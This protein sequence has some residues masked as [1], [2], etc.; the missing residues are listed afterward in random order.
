MAK[1]FFFAFGS[2]LPSDYSGLSPTFIQYYTSLGTTAAPP[3]ITEIIPSSGW[4]MSVV[5]PGQ[6]YGVMFVVDGGVALGSLRYIKGTFDPIQTVDQKIG[7]GADSFGSTSVDPGTIYG[8][9]KRLQELLEGNETFTKSTGVLDIYS[10]G[11]S[12]LLREKT[13]SNTTTTAEKT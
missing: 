3:G 10:R 12:T 2:G 13:L 5:E 11:S 8:L 7:W 6:S 9:T 4:Y 1:P